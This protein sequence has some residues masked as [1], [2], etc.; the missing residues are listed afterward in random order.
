[1]SHWIQFRSFRRRCFTGLVD[2]I[3][4]DCGYCTVFYV[5]VNTV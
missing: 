5:P 3:G 4:L 1:M 2:W